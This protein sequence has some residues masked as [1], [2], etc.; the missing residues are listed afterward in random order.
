MLRT[1]EKILDR[2]ASMQHQLYE[3]RLAAGTSRED[4]AK[5][6]GVVPKTLR[7]WE[8]AYDSPRLT[9]AMSWAWEFGY[10]F[11][12]VGH[13][14]AELLPHLAGE[15]LAKH[16]LR[17]LAAVLEAAREGLRLTQKDLALMVGVTRSSMT[18]WCNASMPP[19]LLALHVWAY[20]V[21]E[22][23]GLSRAGEWGTARV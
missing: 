13:P 9:F 7:D 10:R 8:R 5:R 22:K 6:L 23:V 17:H 21:N 15:E 19:R 11:E 2:V 3:A 20:R 14:M 12:I 16:E 4:L 1:N 18:R